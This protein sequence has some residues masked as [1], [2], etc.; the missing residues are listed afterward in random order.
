MGG[1]RMAGRGG[2][3]LACVCHAPATA[4]AAARTAMCGTPPPSRAISSAGRPRRRASDDLPDASTPAL[5]GSPRHSTRTTPRARA[6]GPARPSTPPPTEAAPCRSSAA[7]A[8]RASAASRSSSPPSRWPP[9]AP[10]AAARGA[11]DSGRHA[12]P[13][14][15]QGGPRPLRPSAMRPSF[16]AGRASGG[17]SCAAPLALPARSSCARPRAAAPR[18]AAG[19]PRATGVP[20]SRR[21]CHSSARSELSRVRTCHGECHGKRRKECEGRA[22]CPESLPSALRRIAT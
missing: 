18:E 7:D 6:R 2:C 15:L 10:R 5:P 12:N 16:A 3:A 11:A 17:A 14:P 8:S 1:L 20:A 4:A 22:K 19:G 21:G 13:T 9:R